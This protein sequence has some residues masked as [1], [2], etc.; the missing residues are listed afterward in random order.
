MT[1]EEMRLRKKELRLTN[2]EISD[3]SGVPLGTVQKIFSGHTASP[4]YETMLALEAVLRPAGKPFSIQT[5]TQPGIIRESAAAYAAAFEDENA[6]KDKQVFQEK[7][8]GEYR[9]S[10]YLALPEDRRCELIDGVLYDMEVPTR[11][12]QLLAGEIHGELRRM[13]RE[14]HGCG[15]PCIPFIA[16]CDVYLDNDDK[17][18]VQP[19][20]F[21]FCGERMK[22][23]NPLSEV[24]NLVVEILSPSTR[25]KDMILK[26]NKYQNAGVEEYWIVD[27][28]KKIVL[29]Y[30]FGNDD[31]DVQMYPF[32]SVI[33]IGISKGACSLDMGEIGSYIRGLE[34]TGFLKPES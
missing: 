17:T 9:V 27:P 30:D 29:V 20:V 15:Q 21:L 3:R 4:R 28:K 19:D 23:E 34:E 25:K 26:L 1:L 18:V 32:E 33:P 22:S 5:D 7:K 10:D 12:H 16:P 14:K 2:Q 8:Q 13:I 11:T 24:P 31:V 6:D